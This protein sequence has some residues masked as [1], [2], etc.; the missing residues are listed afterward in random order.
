MTRKKEEVT[1]TSE[2]IAIYKSFNPDK[3]KIPKWMKKRGVSSRQHQTRKWK[4]LFKIRPGTKCNAFYWALLAKFKDVRSKCHHVDFNWLWSKER[5][6]YREQEGDEKTDLK[7][8]CNKAT[9][10]SNKR[11]TKEHYQSKMEKW[12]SNLRESYSN[13]SCWHL[14][15]QDVG[16]I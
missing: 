3:T 8:P 11:V 13:W 6:I 9:I 4:N 2:L 7:K 1:S 10:Q 16:K 5:K 14:L 12:H 15:W